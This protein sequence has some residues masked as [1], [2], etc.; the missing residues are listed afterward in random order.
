MK[1]RAA[2]ARRAPNAKPPATSSPAANTTFDPN[3]ASPLC[4]HTKV[5][6]PP[7]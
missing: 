7:R 6:S 3:A 1:T 5:R 2:V 4:S